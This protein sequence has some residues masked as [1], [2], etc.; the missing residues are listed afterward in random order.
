MKPP[1]TSLKGPRGRLDARVPRAFTHH[2]GPLARP[3]RVAF[4]ALAAQHGQPPKRSE[5]EAAMIRAAV[6]GATVAL[7]RAAWGE[8]VRKR[9]T[10][11]GRRPSEDAVRAASKDMHRADESLSRAQ[12][13]LS[14]V[15]PPPPPAPPLSREEKER[16]AYLARRGA[17]GAPGQARI[18]DQPGSLPAKPEPG[19]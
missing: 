15:L 16:A 13:A 12:A 19:A 9:E 17:I 7:A 10:G 2:I 5:L 11:K 18:P 4:A 8:L 6:A 3:Y 1:G 14:A